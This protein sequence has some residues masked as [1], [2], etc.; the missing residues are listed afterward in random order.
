MTKRSTPACEGCCAR[1]AH[2]CEQSNNV[3][4][5]QTPTMPALEKRMKPKAF[6][7]STESPSRLCKR[8][9]DP[10]RPP[11]RAPPRGPPHSATKVVRRVRASHS[12]ID[13][14]AGSGYGGARGIC[15]LR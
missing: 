2:A 7:T 4:G 10:T 8:V 11:E 14:G 5:D 9:G 3:P 6:V 12:K 1:E 15:Q 13:S